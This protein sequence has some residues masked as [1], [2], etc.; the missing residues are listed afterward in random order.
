VKIFFM[1]GSSRPGSQLNMPNL[2][3]RRIWVLS[4]LYF[5][6][7]TSTGYFLSMIAEGLAGKYSV[8][9]ICGQPSYSERSTKSPAFEVHNGVRIYR[10]FA[11][12]LDK[13]VPVFKAVNIVTVSVS[14][15]LYSL[16]HFRCGDI[17]LVV[18]NPPLL[19]FLTVLA[20][21]LKGASTA[22][23]VHD[24]YPEVLVAS[25][26]ARPDSLLT[27]TVKWMTCRLYRAVDRIISIGRDMERLVLAKLG[28]RDAKAFPAKSVVITN[29]GEPADIE[30]LPRQENELLRKLG[31]LDKFVIQYAGNIGRTHG[32]EE[33]LAAADLLRDYPRFH[34]LFIGTGARRSFLERG[35]QDR[36][37]TNITVIDPLPRAER[38]VALSACDISVISFKPGMS[39]VS[40]PS[41]MY[42]V[43]ASG[44]PL[45]GICD[46]DS[47]LAMTL[48]ERGLGW[49]VPTRN[50][51]AVAQAIRDIEALPSEVAEKGRRAREVALSVFLFPA[52]N[53]AYLKLIGE[54][55]AEAGK[56]VAGG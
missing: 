20:A 15:F 27:R 1:S 12:T 16:W 39:G 22:L 32:M 6:E 51:Q 10:C 34:F 41:R 43:F 44:K 18:T 56:P 40:V 36:G 46:Q 23:L 13:N 19:P 14:L 9:A 49:V 30:P 21:R 3:N 37:L 55:M 38:A 35:G 2:L 54:M 25:G 8:G 45:L 33:L 29:W 4:E 47:E 5:P 50:P 42:N 48:R 11:T 24:V 53:D 26:M 7:L 28:T 31:L 52:I 17:A